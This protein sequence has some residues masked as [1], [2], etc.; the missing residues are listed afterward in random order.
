MTGFRVGIIGLGV[1]SRFYLAAL[2]SVPSLTLTALCDRDAV[3]LA[4]GLQSATTV[5]GYRDHRELLAAADVDAVIVNVPNDSHYTVCRDALSAGVAVCVEKPL[6]TQLPDAHRLARLA[7]RTRSYLFTSFHRRY[8]DEVRALHTRIAAGPPVRRMT[9]RYHELIE[10]HAGRD[11]WYLD[12][13]R[14]GGGCLADNGPN[15]FDLVRFFLGEVHVVD[16]VIS[17]DLHGVDRQAHI[18]LR[19]GSGAEALVDLD[20]SYPGERKE[21]EVCLAG[22]TVDRADMLAR[23]R[24]F[25][26]SLWHEYVG[27]LCDFAHGLSMRHPPDPANPISPI[28]PLSSISPISST[29][30]DGLAAAELVAACY[31]HGRNSEQDLKRGGVR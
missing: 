27:V 3:R 12:P 25:K 24:G 2:D 16:S 7:R 13:E 1:I 28:S 9:V 6:T 4:D 14:C 5:N 29:G 15:A 26:E 22:G 8:N 31:A 18:V 10:E 23:H 20:W 30:P 21:I 11:R 17:C 19:A